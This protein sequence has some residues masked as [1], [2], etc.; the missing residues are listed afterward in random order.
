MEPWS[1]FLDSALEIIN[2]LVHAATNA[3][4]FPMIYSC[5]FLS[6]P[7]LSVSRASAHKLTF[8]WTQFH[9][10]INNTHRIIKNEV[11]GYHQLFYVTV[12]WKRASWLNI[13]LPNSSQ[14]GSINTCKFQDTERHG[15]RFCAVL[16]TPDIRNCKGP[17]KGPFTSGLHSACTKGEKLYLRW[18]RGSYKSCLPLQTPAIPWNTVFEVTHW[19]LSYLAEASAGTSVNLRGNADYWLRFWFHYRYS[20]SNA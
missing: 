11:D 20:L 2:N 9:S 4:L 12:F 1:G 18:V 8:I 10:L 7:V 5:L 13:C 19:Y 3:G 6:S 16:S 17:Y 14:E 15:L